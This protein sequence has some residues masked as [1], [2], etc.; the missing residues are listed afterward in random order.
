MDLQRAVTRKDRQEH[1]RRI[2]FMQAWH[3]QT[4]ARSVQ[5]RMSPASSLVAIK[6]FSCSLCE[7]IEAMLSL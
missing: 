4:C 5:L 7:D 3:I 2:F 6:A 1:R